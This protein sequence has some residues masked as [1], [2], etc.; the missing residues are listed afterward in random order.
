MKHTL[1][2]IIFTILFTGCTVNFG[3]TAPEKEI[4]TEVTETKKLK[5]WPQGE[6]EYWY[7]KYFLTMALNPQVQTSNATKTCI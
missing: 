1:I 3:K 6:K 5:P 2:I 4:K 7:A